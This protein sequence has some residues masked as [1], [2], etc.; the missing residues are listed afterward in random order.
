MADVQDHDA[1][2][3]DPIAQ[4]TRPRCGHFAAAK[5]RIAS[6]IR[7]FSEAVGD[8]DQP[9]RQPPGRCRLNVSM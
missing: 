3:L 2:L 1:L 8:L 6:P 9:L 7:E 4:D 5:A